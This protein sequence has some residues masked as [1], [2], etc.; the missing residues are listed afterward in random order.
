MRLQVGRPGTPAGRAVVSFVA[1]LC[2]LGSAVAGQIIG[3]RPAAAGTA[4][5][6]SNGVAS[7]IPTD[8]AGAPSGTPAPTQFN[9]MTLVSGGASTVNTSSLV[10]VD[11][12]SNGTTSI[13]TSSTTGIV[14]FAPTTTTTGVQSVVFAYCAPGVTYPSAGSCTTASL[15]IEPV[16][17]LQPMGEASTVAGSPL[18]VTQN[19][20]LSVTGP[21]TAPLGSAITLTDALA[22][23]AIQPSVLIGSQP[24]AV[25]S[26]SGFTYVLPVPSG[27]TYVAGSAVTTGGDANTT[28][29]LTITY[30]SASGSGCTAQ[31][32]T[33]NYHTGYPYI[34]VSLTASVQIAGDTDVTLPTVSAR[35]TVTGAAGTVGD[36]TLTEFLEVLDLA[37]VPSST[38]VT[39]DGYPTQSGTTT[40]PPP[41]QAPV[42]LFST[43]VAAVPGLPTITSVT[44]GT[45]QV[46]I[47]WSAPST[48]GGSPITGYLITEYVS[49]AEQTTYS[50]GNIGNATISGLTNGVT[51][52]FTVSAENANGTGPAS[53]QSAAVTPFTVPASPTIGTAV[54]GDATATVAWTVGA[55]NGASVTGFTI[56]PYIGGTAQTAISVSAVAGSG[57]D[58]TPGN[59]D[60][61]VV[62]G[63][64]N[65]TSYTFSVSQ[66]SAG[67]TS[68]NSV[69]SNAV[70]PVA[71]PSP[72]AAPTIGA[73]TAGSSSATI[74]WTVGAN[75]GS[76]ITDF[77]VTV[78]SGGSVVTTETIP[79]G[80]VGSSFDPTPNATDTASINSLTDGTSYTFTVASKNVGGT[81]PASAQSSSVTPAGVPALISIGAAAPGPSSATVGWTVGANGG[82]PIT[83]FIITSYFGVTSQTLTVDA[84][85]VGSALDPSANATDSYTVTGLTDGTS[86]E[87]RVQAVN[88]IGTSSYSAASSA[89]VPADLPASPIIGA[90]SP[91]NAS[92][93]VA[94]TVGGNLGS[95][96]TSFTITPTIGTTAQTP[97]TVPAGA[98]GSS[99]DPTQGA[100]DNYT[101]T[102]LANGTAYTFTVT[103]TNGVGTSSPSAASNSVTPAGTAT[104]PGAPTIGTA[105]AGNA[106]ATVTWTAPANTG[107]DPITGYVI[108]PSS[109]SPVT[110][111][112]VTSDT[113]TGLTNGT[114]YTFTVAAINAVGTGAAS[115][116]SNSVTP[117]VPAT[118]PGAPT[119]GTAT[120]GNASATVTW[121]APASNGGSAITGYVITPSSGSPVTVGNVTSDT[122]TGLTNGTAYTFRVAAINAVGTGAQSAA[123]NSVTP[124]SVPGA[125][126][127]GTATAGNASATVTWT[128]P[129]SNGGS[130][131]TGYVITPSSGSPVTVGNVTS[132]D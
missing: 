74:T 41:Y 16:A 19:V 127:I 129:A 121:T 53:A 115:A 2:I 12:P 99:L 49:G 84:G 100:L 122:V 15:S 85:G 106:S 82:S 64:T 54:A 104:V 20:G 7:Y 10:V 13:A 124:A 79:A 76:A 94:W 39:V 131:I 28:S 8:V 86:Y 57:T 73:A 68:A 77:V 40:N 37:T 48:N 75:N 17:T 107:G 5:V 71:T 97:I 69:E 112:N 91:G 63:L 130:P 103:A 21:S 114:A 132:D 90:A 117:A 14:T 50:L 65:G 18:V 3:V 1:I 35:F 89:V 93:T 27:L 6:I 105:T 61:Y 51:Y 81:G 70:T 116:S 30:C 125:P 95:A 56:T 109:G 123:T 58:P 102:A 110:V 4:P 111:G 29:Q 120:A 42:T 47:V 11:S 59:Q 87:F 32:G 62:T 72:P 9:V 60:S 88:A 24:T 46:T 119:I 98:V 80:A 45:G 55:N 22:P 128:A 44:P 26:A 67:G 92:A 36:Q 31:I 33:G 83:A 38:D 108:T 66:I 52:T 126:T 23:F 118:V 34:E 25:N 96:I 78:W 43:T 101:V 113:V